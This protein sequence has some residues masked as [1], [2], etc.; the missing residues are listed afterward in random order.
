MINQI[1]SVSKLE[2][3]E[4]DEFFEMLSSITYKKVLAD[5]DSN[6]GEFLD[7]MQRKLSSRIE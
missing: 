5:D 2:M 1:S 6:N 7:S 3:W 4:D